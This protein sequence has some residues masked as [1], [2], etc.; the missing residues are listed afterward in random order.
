MTG[1]LRDRLPHLPPLYKKRLLQ[2]FGAYLVLAGAFAGWVAWKNDAARTAWQARVPQAEAEIKHVNLTPQVSSLGNSDINL[3][4]IHSATQP[5]GIVLIMT[6]LGLSKALDER[7]LNDL[8]PPVALAFSPY[9][10]NTK[11]AAGD[12]AKKKRPVIAL[13]PMEP[14]TYPLDDPGPRALSTRN[15]D[16][17]NAENLAAAIAGVPGATAAMNFMGSRYLTEHD[18]V[19]QLLRG[20]SNRKLVT[21]NAPVALNS[22]IAE[23]ARDRK[24]PL[25]NVDVFVDDK[26][27]E[28]DIRQKLGELE[29]LARSNGVAVGVVRPLPLT[30]ALLNN[31]LPTL[32]GRNLRL[33]APT[34]PAALNPAAETADAGKEPDTAETPEAPPAP[35]AAVTKDAAPHGHQ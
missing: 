29:T 19:E 18:A 11:A 15:S 12:A 14:T 4:D 7:A 23:I 32:E 8:P 5:G 28:A 33:V 16:K 13:I 31:W 10:G 3:A 30:F 27:T 34:D 17:E 1:S 2:G 20:L 21:I 9:G 35:P 24:A 25:L 6:D 22:P 26:A